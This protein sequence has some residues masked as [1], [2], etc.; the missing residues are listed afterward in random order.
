[1]EGIDLHVTLWPAFP[2]F[3]RFA[4][5]GNRVAGIRLN[6]AMINQAELED[7]VGVIEPGRTAVPLHFDI[8]GRQLRVVEVL[9]SPDRLDI[10]LNH[11]IKVRTPTPV[12]FKAGA[13]DALLEEVSEDGRRLTFRPGGPR[14]MVRP[15]E[16]LHI[17]HPSLEVGGPQFTDAELAKIATVR[18][19]GCTR[20]YLSYVESQDDVDEFLDLVGRDAEVSLKIESKKG[21]AYVEREFVKRPNLRLVAARGDLYV[22]LDR[23]HEML[24]ALKAIIAK[25]PEAVVGSRILLSM[26]PPPPR[27]DDTEATVPSCADFL[28]LGWLYD[29]GYRAM[30]L[31]DELCLRRKLLSAAVNAFDSF[32]QAY[33]GT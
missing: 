20:W 23:P 14:F 21:L 27:D 33:P 13:D 22:E 31:C 15:G 24:G 28:E 7:A 18:A 8:K 6:S 17:R 19:A 2:H 12:L 32:R 4:S 11:P 26:I 3:W 5:D 30:L 25:D 16:S 9:G 1:M 10:R 29:A